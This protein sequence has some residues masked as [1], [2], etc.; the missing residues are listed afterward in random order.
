MSVVQ[1]F[2]LFVKNQFDKNVKSIDSDNGAKFISDPMKQFYAKKG[3]IYQKSCVDTPQQN[4]R[5]PYFKCS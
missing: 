5:A 1:N 2:G 4:G 3:I